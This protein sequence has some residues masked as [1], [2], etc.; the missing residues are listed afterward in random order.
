MLA[1]ILTLCGTMSV[2][3]QK[4]EIVDVDGNAVPYASVMTADATLIGVTGMDGVIA[5]IEGAK[6]VVISHVAYQPKTVAVEA[7][8]LRVTLE[9]A[10]FN[11]PEITVTKKDYTYLQRYYRVVII[12]KDGVL[13]YRSGIRQLPQRNKWQAGVI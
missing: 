8:G 13:Y 12:N 2:N 1:A 6:T 10:D 3:A 5:D 9:D 11:L 7:D 4:I